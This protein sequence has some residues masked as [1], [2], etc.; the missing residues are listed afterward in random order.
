M[1]LFYFSAA[2]MFQFPQF[3][4][5]TT[6]QQNRRLLE[7]K[8]CCTYWP[9]FCIFMF[10]MVLLWSSPVSCRCWG[11][12]LPPAG[13]PPPAACWMKTPWF[14]MPDSVPQE[15]ATFATLSWTTRSSSPCWN[16]LSAMSRVSSLSS[17]L[18]R[19]TSLLGYLGVLWCYC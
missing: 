12:S 13:L 8:I 4:C 6:T 14:A 1:Y 5:W 9:S 7:S 11:P 18:W 19:N 16:N 3:F 10:L 2:T 15:P 17:I